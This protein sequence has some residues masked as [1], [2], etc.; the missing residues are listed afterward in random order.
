MA[1]KGAAFEATLQVE[2]GIGLTERSS[3]PL[4]TSSAQAGQRTHV[5]GDWYEIIGPVP[6]LHA[7]RLSLSLPSLSAVFPLRPFES[8]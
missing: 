5:G 7:L 6:M 8:P 2:E 4:A 1:A 3:E